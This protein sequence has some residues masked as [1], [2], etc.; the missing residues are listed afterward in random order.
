MYCTVLY[1]SVAHILIYSMYLI[2]IVI[3]INSIQAIF[4]TFK[5]VFYTYYKIIMLVRSHSVLISHYI[6]LLDIKY[7]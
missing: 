5:H 1:D 3:V 2:N 7:Y 4:P 6:Q